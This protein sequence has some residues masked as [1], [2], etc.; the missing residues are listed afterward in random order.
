MESS[1]KELVLRTIKAQ[2]SYVL[3]KFKDNSKSLIAKHLNMLYSQ[4]SVDNRKDISFENMRQIVQK[5]SS[6]IGK[7][8]LFRRLFFLE[9]H[10]ANAR[11]FAADMV[12]QIIDSLE[13]RFVTGGDKLFP[14]LLKINSSFTL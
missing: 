8:S 14:E 3:T 12:C 4:I 9:D 10:D 13:Y 5:Y 6:N 2:Q 1:I 7:K 11:I